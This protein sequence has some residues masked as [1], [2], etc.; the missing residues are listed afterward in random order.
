MPPLLTSN[1]PP[2]LTPGRR[3]LPMRKI[4][5]RRCDAPCFQ[6]RITDAN[7]LVNPVKRVDL[8]QI[9]V[10]LGHHLGNLADNH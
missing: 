10:N 3:P 8:G 1:P 4:V 6:L 9:R 2:D 5:G 7:D